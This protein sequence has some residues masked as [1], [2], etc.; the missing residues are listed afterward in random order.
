[1]STSSLRIIATGLIAQYPLG[2]VTWD[3]VQYVLGLDRLGH[4]VYYVEDTGEWPYNP[5]EGGLASEESPCRYNVEYLNR[6]MAQFGMEDRWAYRF[7]DEEW[8]GLRDEKRRKVIETA[9]LLI[10][11]SGTLH[12]PAEYH[13][14]DTLAYIDS[15]PVFTQIQLMDNQPE[16]EERAAG[17]DAHDVHFS[18]GECLPGTLPCTKYEWLP[19]RQPVVV[20]EW[21]RTQDYREAYTTVMNWTSYEGVTLNGETYGQKNEEMM[22]FANLPAR[23]DPVTL[24]LALNEG[25]TE[26]P[27]RPL[28]EQKGWS[29]VDPDKVCPDLE[30]YRT[31]IQGSKGEWSVAKN[32]YVKGQPGWFSC[33]SACYLAAGRPVIV[34]DTG[35]QPVIP[36]GEGVLVFSKIEEAVQAIRSVETNY[37]HHM[38]AALEIAREYFRAEGVLKRLIDRAFSSTSRPANQSTV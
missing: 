10:N 12:R 34:Q 28:L 38:T 27:P 21:S 20:S 37:E 2:G 25:K 17:I 31:Y 29:V 1:M 5:K 22:R 32:G 9:D 7:C 8:Y 30:S 35:F 3:Y 36:T 33:R 4:D 13:S 26:H 11:V 24:E 14:V 23:V 6:V 18:F 19:T 16:A 15:D